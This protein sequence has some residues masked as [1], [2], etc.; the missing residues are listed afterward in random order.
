MERLSFFDQVAHK[1]STS[2]LPDLNMQGAMIL[3]P[4]KSPFKIDARVIAEHIAAR[5]SEF[6]ILRKKLVQDPLRI[7]DVRLIDDPQ[8]DVWDHISFATLP[9]PGNQECLHAHLAKFSAQSLDFTR[10]LWRFEIIEGLEGDK[11]ALVQKLSHAT[12]DGMA[13]FKIM[14]NLF[15]REPVPPAKLGKRSWKADPEPGRVKLLADAVRENVERVGVHT[16]R[17]LWYLS[18]EISKAAIQRVGDRFA[19]NQTGEK[20]SAKK[21]G[22]KA[23]PTSI[24]GTISADLRALAFASF[25]L[26]ELKA[27][28][29]ALGC[30]LNDLCLAMASEALANY[31][32]G[33]GEKVD[34][35]LVFVMPIST[36]EASDKD[37]GNALALAMISAHNTIKSIS[38]RLRAIH[39]DTLEAK[40]NQ[41]TKQATKVDV[42]DVTS[43][44]SPLLIDWATLILNRIQPWNKLPSPINAVM[45]NVPGPPWTFYFAGMPIEYQIPIVPVFHKGALSIGATSM[46]NHFSFGF[47]ACG[48]VVKQEDMHLLVDG[49]NNAFAEL[50]KIAA[51]KTPAKK[52]VKKAARKAK[53]RPGATNTV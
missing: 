5:L 12:M 23:R 46:G 21:A 17:T 29:K 7:G 40:S 48:K 43:M 51:S 50:S 30:K 45:T 26:D 19:D 31:F 39:A 6:P 25:E 27:V 15:D 8:F 41:T 36:R 20:T 28:S 22:P 16:P 32:S 33:I 2:G 13:A 11:I 52:P 10:S 47:H 1:I 4:A 53:T 34:F 35:D 49:L 9:A 38:A 44:L 18:K 37:H 3:D 24:N 14:Q 42:P